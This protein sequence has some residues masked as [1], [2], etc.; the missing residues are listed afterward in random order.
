MVDVAE[1][2]TGNNKYLKEM[3]K[4][5][6]LDLIRTNRGLSRKALADLTGLSATATGAI[7]KNLLNENFI[8][9]VGEGKSS[10][11]RKPVMLELK[12]DSYFAIGFD[13]DVQFIYTVVLDITGKIVHEQ[14]HNTPRGLSPAQA[15]Q[16]IADIY[17]KTISRMK[18]SQDQ[19]L[20]AGVSVPGMLDIKTRRILLA[21]NL[22]WVDVDLLD[23]LTHLLNS[24]V[25]LD[26][27]A[28][29][30]ALCENWLGICKGVEDFICVNIESGIGAG[31]FLRGKM[32]RGC[33]GSAGDVGH[34]PVNEKGQR[35]KCGNIGC[36]ETI[37][38]INA[39]TQSYQALTD[40]GTSHQSERG[41]DDFDA[42][43]QS[44]R[45]GDERC[46]KIIKD[47]ASSLG[48][49]LGYLINA[50]NPQKIVLGKKFPQYADLAIEDVRETAKKYAL[51]H[52]AGTCSI[53]A[54]SFGENSSALGAAI[55]PIRK[56][57]GR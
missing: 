33:S 57:F 4:S 15:G 17:K 22:E 41:S 1:K 5:T 10:G 37:A 28:M 20:G 18:L 12:P 46:T 23:G 19:I 50:L 36:L 34:I 30:S 49:A 8:R 51:S 55:I 25:Y 48:K 31:N 7:V 16:L 9:E 43:I 13:I 54:S 52:P 2:K 38:S 6:V 26:N 53:T 21:P 32:Y 27:E 35:C 42:L 11:G 56:L 44:A 47:A 14:K 39:M 24:P 29:C 3:N 40:D 45:S